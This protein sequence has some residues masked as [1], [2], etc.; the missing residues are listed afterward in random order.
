M[1]VQH[2][3]PI[4]IHL[5][6]IIFM[7]LAA[8]H[9]SIRCGPLTMHTQTAIHVAEKIMKV[10]YKSHI[11]QAQGL[12]RVQTPSLSFDSQVLSKLLARRVSRCPVD[13]Q[14]WEKMIPKLYQI[15]GGKCLQATHFSNSG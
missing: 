9:S 8:G 2:C 6:L 5:Q 13:A 14:S 3:F 7:A 12:T 4:F 15:Y 10:Q 11:K 1:N